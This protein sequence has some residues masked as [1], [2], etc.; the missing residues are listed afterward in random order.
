ME[1]F[2]KRIRKEW[3]L[4]L[5]ILLST[6][7]FAKVTPQE[8]KELDKTL[9]DISYKLNTNYYSEKDID[10]KFSEKVLDDY[11]DMLDYNHQYFLDGEV[12][13]LKKKWGKKLDDSFLNGDSTAGFE[14][15]DKYYNAVLRVIGIE[16][17]IIK[18]RKKLDFTKNEK[19][20]YDREKASYFK[21][22][23]ELKDHWRKKVKAAI[24]SIRETEDLSM[25]EAF[26]RLSKRLEIK[27][28]LL[29]KKTKDDIFSTFV[30]AYLKEYDPHST[31][32][33]Q[34]E[35]VEFNISMK[36]E[37]SGIGAT[38]TSE[39]GY[40][41]IVKLVPKGPADK[42]KELHPE[43]KIIGIASDGKNF[44]DVVDWPTTD[45]VNLIR[46]KAGTIVKLRII[47]NGSK[48]SKVITIKREKIKLEENSAKYFIKTIKGKEKNYKI[49]VISLPSFYM[50]FEGYLKNDPNY[51]STTRD[52][53]KIIEK[54]NKEGV[55][56]LV[57]DLRNNGGGSLMEVNSLMGLFIKSGPV[58]QVKEDGN[59]NY[60]G[61]TDGKIYFTK[62]V[63]VMIN[64]L[65]AS[66]SEIFA[67]AMQDSGRGIVV[68]TTS[69][70]KGSVQT[71]QKL[72]LGEVKFTTG[73]F[74][75]ISGGSTQHKGVTP[76]ILFPNTYNAKEV[77]ESSLKNPLPWDE[78]G[79]LLKKKGSVK[80]LDI[81][82]KNHKE[83]VVK[84]PSFI[85]DEK[86]YELVE[87][88]NKEKWVL[89]NKDERE[90]ERK[91]EDEEWL[92][93]AN[94]KF[95]G[96]GKPQLKDYKALEEYN[97]KR[98]KKEGIELLKEDGEIEE[99]GHILVDMIKLSSE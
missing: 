32:F 18:N 88:I 53:L 1:G 63:A 15:H 34:K 44:E 86:K 3:L 87:K 58:V 22:E 27:K 61:D 69:F 81:L 13:E 98:N 93:L 35:L 95:K 96:E 21:S 62:P 50:D 85:Y 70:G 20:F 2:M 60:L 7:T 64:R 9:W 77:G 76:D 42:G 89:L 19:L 83:R 40:L 99:T 12:K 90:K 71:V 78:V 33:S 66:A 46:G 80:N 54:L 79:S 84:N 4:V 55:D 82:R 56:G 38:I 37:L 29:D 48:K 52:I 57:I 65:S 14:I 36:L 16:E 91:K 11:L 92:K 51:R 39:K 26:K 8:K 6:L 23:E 72:N 24:L 49:G 68:G 74:Y 10:D 43:D 5:L 94:E 30:N 73:K 97:K 59:V 41:K 67:A 17:E 25:K 75:R 47:P 45:A 31:Y 28:K